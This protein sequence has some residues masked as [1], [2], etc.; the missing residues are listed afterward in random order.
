MMFG[1]LGVDELLAQHLAHLFIRDPICL[2][3]EKIYQSIEEDVDHFEVVVSY[4]E[5]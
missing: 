1:V 4:Y 2:Y 5:P 3:E